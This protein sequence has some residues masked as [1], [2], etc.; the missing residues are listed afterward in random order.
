MSLLQVHSG[1]MIF[2]K[3]LGFLANQDSAGRTCELANPALCLHVY[4]SFQNWTTPCQDEKPGLNSPPY[5]PSLHGEPYHGERT[6]IM[7]LM[8]MEMMM[9]MM[10]LMAATA[11]F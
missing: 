10:V 4:V 3:L 11:L 5:W 2:V 9:L 6:G 7:V 8:I 1:A